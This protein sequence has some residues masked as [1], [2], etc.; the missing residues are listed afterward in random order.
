MLEKK[1]SPQRLIFPEAGDRDRQIRIFQL[2]SGKLAALG[3][4]REPKTPKK[5]SSGIF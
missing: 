2:R 5:R 3:A 1:A 4:T